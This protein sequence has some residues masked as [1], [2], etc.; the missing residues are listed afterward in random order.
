MVLKGIELTIGRK[1]DIRTAG[2]GGRGLALIES[3]GPFRCGFGLQHAWDGRGGV[4]PK[5]ACQGQGCRYQ[6]LDGGANFNEVS[7]A[8]RMG[9][10]FRLIGKPCPTEDLEENLN[11]ALKQYRTVSASGEGY[12]ESRHHE[13]PQEDY[14]DFG[15]LKAVALSPLSAGQK[16]VTTSWPASSK[17]SD[18]WLPEL[19]STFYLGYLDLPDEVQEKLYKNEKVPDEIADVV[20]V[21]PN[22]AKEILKGILKLEE[23]TPIIFT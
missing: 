15:R 20:K 18:D 9:A 7:D 1:Y 19:A 22:F 12:V 21:F 2:L 11:Q 6:V 13:R 23:I 14:F 17:L 8:V 5:G 10:I 16:I 3:E 4:S